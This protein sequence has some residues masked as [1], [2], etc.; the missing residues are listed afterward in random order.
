M[1]ISAFWCDLPCSVLSAPSQT[2]AFRVQV[3]IIHLMTER[4]AITKPIQPA[5]W[6]MIVTTSAVPSV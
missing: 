5:L 1:F 3:N 6:N 2:K 4:I